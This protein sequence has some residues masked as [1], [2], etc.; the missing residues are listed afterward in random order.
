LDEIVYRQLSPSFK[1]SCLYFIVLY[2]YF[3]IMIYGLIWRPS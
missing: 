2:T 3:M 1:L